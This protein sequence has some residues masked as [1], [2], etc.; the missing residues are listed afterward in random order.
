[1]VNNE[2]KKIPAGGNSTSIVASGFYWP[3]GLA[4]DALGDIYINDFLNTAIKEIPADGGPV[5]T[6]LSGVRVEGF[7]LD[8]SKN[9]YFIEQGKTTIKKFQRAGGTPSL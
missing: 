8:A 1:M 2:V 5:T 7:V 3:T 6:L 4:M 9:M